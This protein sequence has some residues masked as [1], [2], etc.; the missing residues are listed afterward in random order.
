MMLQKGRH[1][2][3]GG[4]GILGAVHRRLG[5]IS[6]DAHLGDTFGEWSFLAVADGHGAA[7]HFRSDRGARLAVEAARRVIRDWTS[8]FPDQAV[9][10]L[11]LRAGIIDLPGLLSAQW[12]AYVD[13][14]LQAHPVP[15]DNHELRFVPYGSTLA[16]IAISKTSALVVQIGDGDVILDDGSGILKR[17]LA[18][19]H[20]LVGEQTYSLCL[21]DPVS[22][23]RYA[24]L[25]LS[26]AQPTSRPFAI[27]ATD[28]LLKSYRSEKMF[29]QA[30]GGWRS[31]VKSH[32]LERALTGLQEWLISVT[33]QGNGD[34]IS[35]MFYA[36]G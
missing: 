14:D 9:A 34:D 4:A 12:R 5:T 15:A 27:A 30:I 33:E 24:V 7:P 10:T 18:A 2:T 13:A 16:A 23:F 6:Q 22:H 17:P 20:G 29:M 25:D 21:P 28:G 1:G 31:L 19:D 3:V 35:L 26:V 36:G 8:R 32:G 11:D